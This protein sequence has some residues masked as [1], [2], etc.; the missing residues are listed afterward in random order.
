MVF[1]CNMRQRGLNL[2]NIVAKAFEK[3]PYTLAMLR[4]DMASSGNTE[5]LWVKRVEILT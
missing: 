5:F 4:V 1:S 2:Y 3:C